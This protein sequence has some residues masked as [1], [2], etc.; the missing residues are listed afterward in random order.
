MSSLE[1]VSMKKGRAHLP[2]L[3]VPYDPNKPRHA[4]FWSDAELAI[5]RQYFPKGGASAV[6]AKLPQR[7]RTAI[8]GLA[9]KLGLSAPGHRPGTKHARYELTAGLE[10]RI[11]ETWPSLA[12]KGA[13]A[14]FAE[15][16]DRPRWWLEKQAVKLGLST[17]QRKEPPWTPAEDALMA[18]VPLHAPAK[19]S[20]IFREHG[21][22]RTPTAIVVRSKR[23]GLKRRYKETLSGTSL[24]VILGVDNKT[25]TQWC[26]AGLLKATRRPSQRLPQQGGAPWSI[27]RADARQFVIDNIASIDIRKV[28]KVLFVDLLV[29]LGEGPGP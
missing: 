1:T 24:A 2:R 22:S 5:M 6:M 7:S 12:A 20:E 28:D 21:F 10:A 9:H 15:Q 17:L 26:V 3:S 13:T 25:T 8:Y 4:R 19:C 11:R 29:N 27:T 18:K 14:K 23:L 16:I